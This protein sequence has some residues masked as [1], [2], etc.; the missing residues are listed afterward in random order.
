MLATSFRSPDGR[1]KV[2]WEP[3]VLT[4]NW[5]T[6]PAG[7]AHRKV[8]VCCALA[9]VPSQIGAARPSAAAKNRCLIGPSLLLHH[10]FGP[11]LLD[12]LADSVNDLLVRMRLA[13]FDHLVLD[14]AALLEVGEVLVSETVVP[15]AVPGCEGVGVFLVGV[16]EL[17]AG[18]RL[19]VDKAVRVGVAGER[20]GIGFR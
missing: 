20:H 6:W 2:I 7:A 14:F 13:I 4:A 9:A 18:Q 12:H 15:A 17:S 10:P 5:H 1:A 11:I 16:G 3:P 8:T 19:H